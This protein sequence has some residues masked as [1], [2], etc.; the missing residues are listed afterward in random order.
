LSPDF[1]V[2]V[3]TCMVPVEDLLHQGKAEL[4]CLKYLKLCVSVPCKQV[5]CLGVRL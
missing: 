1:A 4:F 3:E 2:D 5:P